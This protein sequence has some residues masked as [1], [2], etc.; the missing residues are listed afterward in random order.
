[1]ADDGRWEYDC[2]QYIDFTE[3]MPFN[4]GA[5]KLFGKIILYSG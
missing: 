3:P 2:P 5:D 4:D 1:M